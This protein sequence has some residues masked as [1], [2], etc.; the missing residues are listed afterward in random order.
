LYNLLNVVTITNNLWG[1]L[2]KT[3]EIDVVRFMDAARVAADNSE[4]ADFVLKQILFDNHRPA[5]RE[6][7]I[8]LLDTRGTNDHQDKLR[9]ALMLA[10]ACPDFLSIN[11]PQGVLT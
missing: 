10:V 4:F 7:M 1:D 5:L 11:V 2:I 3:D 6:Q 9:D 8:A